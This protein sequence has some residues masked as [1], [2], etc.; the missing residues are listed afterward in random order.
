MH[1]TAFQTQVKKYGGGQ[2]S[3]IIISDFQ[4]IYA[5]NEFETTLTRPTSNYPLN[6]IDIETR[7]TF[8]KT[9][10]N[11]NPTITTDITAVTTNLP[12]VRT[13]RTTAN[14]IYISAASTV[15]TLDP[16]IIT[17]PI[18]TELPTTHYRYRSTSNFPI[19]TSTSRSVS[20]INNSELPST[21]T[22]LKNNESEYVNILD[23][24]ADTQSIPKIIPT[25]I[26]KLTYVF[27]PTL[28][29]NCQRPITWIA[30]LKKTTR[31]KYHGY[32]S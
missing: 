18:Y 14:G 31:L 8:F 4:Q 25:I 23:S 2:K 12:D 28:C 20:T 29:N 22:Y 15:T 21:E 30:R 19:S 1:Y 27:R 24:S 5:Q 10:S 7:S 17:R 32:R 3:A 16:S 6:V 26:D 9:I 11:F 13:H